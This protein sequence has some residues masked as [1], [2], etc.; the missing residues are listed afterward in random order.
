MEALSSC[1]LY[2]QN[3]TEICLQNAQYIFGAIKLTSV[4]TALSY[5]RGKSAS[6]E[7][8]KMKGAIIQRSNVRNV[9][10]TLRGESSF[11]L[12]VTK[13]VMVLILE[14]QPKIINF[15]VLCGFFKLQHCLLTLL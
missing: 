6:K 15:R 7:L 1:S 8:F 14:S 4:Y 2:C 13:L 9:K 11:N 5:H 10:I 3:I 12:L